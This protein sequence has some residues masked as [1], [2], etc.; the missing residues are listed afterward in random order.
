MHV[1][2]PYQSFMKAAGPHKTELPDTRVTCVGALLAW[3]DAHLDEV[4]AARATY[5]AQTPNCPPPQERPS[6][7]G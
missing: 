7:S 1:Q 6:A 5:D 3:A 4:D 2:N